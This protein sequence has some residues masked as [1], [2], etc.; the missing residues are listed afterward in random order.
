MTTKCDNCFVN[1]AIGYEK[2]N[3]DLAFCSELCHFEH[4]SSH[5]GKKLTKKKARE[6]LH[7]GTVH[8]HPLTEKQRRYFGWVSTTGGTEKQIGN[9]IYDVVASNKDARKEIFSTPQMSMFAVY[10]QP[11][12]ELEMEVHPNATQFFHVVK[13]HG[14]AI[15]DGVKQ[16]V[17]KKSIFYVPANTKHRIVAHKDGLCMYTIYAPSEH[18][19]IHA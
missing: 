7:H 19:T 8:G 14:N 16:H 3:P 13:G 10:L 9:H 17:T 4:I 15:I 12:Q 11:G 2:G 5:S 18:E 1:N 6:I